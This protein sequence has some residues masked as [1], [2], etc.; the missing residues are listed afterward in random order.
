[1]QAPPVSQSGTFSV[2]G[3]TLREGRPGDCLR[4][5]VTIRVGG[6]ESVQSQTEFIEEVPKF[7]PNQS[8][9]SLFSFEA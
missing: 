5:R 4:V 3:L 7:I 2:G 6:S 9:A 8:Q 1:M